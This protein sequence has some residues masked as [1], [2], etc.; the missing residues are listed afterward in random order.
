MKVAPYFQTSRL[1]SQ[2]VRAAVAQSVALA[3]ACLLSYEL[4]TQ[5][6]AHVYS[7]SASDDLI[8]G[9]WA[10]MAT[11]FV[12]RISYEE[13]VAAAVGQIAATL[14]SFGLCL[15]YLLLLPSTIWGLATLIGVGGIV[16]TLAGRPRDAATTGIS[17]TVVMVVAALFPHNAWEQPILRL[18]DTAVGVA[19]GVAAAWIGLQATG[20]RRRALPHDP[21]GGDPN[22]T[23][24]PGTGKE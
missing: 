5:L 3:I 23:V 19:V 4:I 20:L 9:M 10:V 21:G 15:V 17:T 8:G 16:M 13:S 7:L 6:L 2:P 12:F 24:P 18:V 14:V 11:I 1:A 22:H